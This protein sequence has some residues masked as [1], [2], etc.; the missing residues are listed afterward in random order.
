MASTPNI[1]IQG[2]GA[3]GAM[4]ASQ[5]HTAGKAE[6]AF[7][8]TGERH[9][10]LKAHGVVVNGTRYVLP[11]LSPDDDAPPADLIIVALK[12]KDLPGAVDDLAGRVGEHTL[13][14]SVMNGLDSEAIIAD[15]WGWDNVLYAY[16]V[17]TDAT[18]EGN[19]I[20][21]VSPGRIVFGEAR[22]PLPSARV[23]RVQ[24]LLDLGGI[25]HETPADMLRMLWWKFMVNVGV[26]QASALLNAPYGVFHRSEH[27]RAIMEAAMREVIAIAAIEGIDLGP[28]DLADWHPV[29]N[30]LHP[31]GKTS[32]LQDVEAGRQ[33]EVDIFA[34]KVIALGARHGIPTPVNDM[35]WHALKVIEARGNNG[36]G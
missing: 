13:I 33:T 7:A 20:N 10:R 35:L 29:L 6:V 26:N 5:F 19:A 23:Q 11:V 4:Y 16:A 24:A 27:A 36:A 3:L 34:G 8:A 30:T 17:G 21:Y 25:K 18:R 12:D 9:A 31:D 15:R 32:M 14:I 1:V 2:A 28:Q 22:N